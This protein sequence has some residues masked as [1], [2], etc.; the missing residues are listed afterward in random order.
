MYPT[1]MEVRDTLRNTAQNTISLRD[2]RLSSLEASANPGT[3]ETHTLSINDIIQSDQQN[4]VITPHDH[5]TMA[6]DQEN[7]PLLS[8][9][10]TEISLQTSGTPEGKGKTP[11]VLVSGGLTLATLISAAHGISAADQIL[12]A[13]LHTWPALYQYASHLN[14]GIDHIAKQLGTSNFGHTL[15]ND[16]T[17][18]IKQSS[19]QTV[20]DLEDPSTYRSIKLNL[21]PV[22][23]GPTISVVLSAEEQSAVGAGGI[24]KPKRREF[25]VDLPGGSLTLT[26]PELDPQSEELT[27]EQQKSLPISMSFTEKHSGAEFELGRISLPILHTSA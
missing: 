4:S 7:H 3:I 27:G 24:I 17:E 6:L 18:L 21:K 25:S 22:P 13:K 15:G 19:V 20:A 16:L 14:S 1:G 26:L 10:L 2:A 12:M 23:G 5:S 8:T 11:T 9:L